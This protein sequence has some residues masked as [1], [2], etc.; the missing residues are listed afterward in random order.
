MFSEWDT[1]DAVFP[2]YAWIKGC[3]AWA[4]LS[5]SA[6]WVGCYAKYIIFKDTNWIEILHVVTEFDS[7][8]L[9]GANGFPPLNGKKK[10]SGYV[11]FAM[12][13]AQV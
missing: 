11:W 5:K 8:F 13:G 1:F 2:C 7:T 4:L 3:V 12:K 10:M 6:D 9:H